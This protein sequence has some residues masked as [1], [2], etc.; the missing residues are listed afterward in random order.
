MSITLADVQ[1][2]EAKASVEAPVA[3]SFKVPAVPVLDVEITKLGTDK[4]RTRYLG[5]IGDG[6]VSALVYAPGDMPETFKGETLELTLKGAESKTRDGR[7]KISW[8]QETAEGV[9]LVLAYVPEEASHITGFKLQ[10][11]KGN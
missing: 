9:L 10:F 2:S 4:A 8:T 3:P 5:E 6:A 11:P 7:T 1:A